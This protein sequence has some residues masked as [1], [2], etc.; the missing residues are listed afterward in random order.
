MRR[1]YRNHFYME[2][3]QISSEK[4]SPVSDQNNPVFQILALCLRTPNMPLSLIFQASNP[5]FWTAS[6]FQ[7]SFSQRLL[8][9]MTLLS[10]SIL[11]VLL[12]C[13]LS[14]L[15]WCG[16]SWPFYASGSDRKRWQTWVMQSS[17]KALTRAF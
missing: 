6:Q 7:E 8:F 12:L 2:V 13:P 15:T 1:Q 11:M 17:Y 16:I 14:V 5:Q 4:P 10:S 3:K 9:F